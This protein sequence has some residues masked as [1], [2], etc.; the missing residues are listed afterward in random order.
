[1]LIVECCSLKQTSFILVQCP[2]MMQVVPAFH[3]RD[4]SKLQALLIKLCACDR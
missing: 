3:S 4:T 2:M 1:M